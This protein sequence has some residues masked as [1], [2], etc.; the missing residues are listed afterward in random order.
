MV[1]GII[2]AQARFLNEG[3]PNCDQYLGMLN[4][5]DVVEECTSQVYEG[6]ISMMQPTASWGARYTRLQ[7][8]VPGVYAVKVIGTVS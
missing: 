8:Y 7:D 6:T 2:L 5:P 3:C 1:C 4:A